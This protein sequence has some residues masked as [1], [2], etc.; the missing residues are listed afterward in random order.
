MKKLTFFEVS[1]KLDGFKLH[2]VAYLFFRFL[3]AVNQICT[4]MKRIFTHTALLVLLF[5]ASAFKSPETDCATYSK[6]QIES[7]IREVFGAQADELV[8]NNHSNR[9]QLIEN[10]LKRVN[11]SQHPELAGKKFKLLSSVALQNKYNPAMTRDL[12]YNAATF[13]PLKY[14]FP[15]ASRQ[16]EVFRIDNSDFLIIIEPIQ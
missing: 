14:H 9:L 16:R 3:K 5:C 4:L 7:F 8:F 10:F 2:F 6:T 13:N 12:V 1:F 15:M 11:V